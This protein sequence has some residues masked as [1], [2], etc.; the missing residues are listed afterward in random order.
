MPISPLSPPGGG[1][2]LNG[3]DPKLVLLGGVALK[4]LVRR[5]Q[6]VARQYPDGG[7]EYSSSWGSAEPPP[8]AD[9]P[10][11]RLKA[12]LRLVLPSPKPETDLY[13]PVPPPPI[14]VLELDGEVDNIG[15]LAAV[16]ATLRALRPFKVTTLSLRNCACFGVSSNGKSDS[17]AD[18]AKVNG[19]S[20]SSADVAIGLLAAFLEER[21]FND[22]PKA[23]M[24]KRPV[25]ACLEV[26]YVSGSVS[27]KPEPPCDSRRGVEKIWPPPQPHSCPA[28][29]PYLSTK[30]HVLSPFKAGAPGLHAFVGRAK[31]GREA[32]GKRQGE[33]REKEKVEGAAAEEQGNRNSGSTLDSALLAW[34]LDCIYRMVVGARGLMIVL[35]RGA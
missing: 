5:A 14:Q 8:W 15:A 19:K 26:L 22:P 27:R 12:K 28:P 35:R 17:S 2:R 30:A 21:R 9:L 24:D 7:G 32:E 11:C 3:I 16:L 29:T 23:S 33:K 20:D 10:D 6:V 4:E 25:E 18:V 1:V 13:I 34:Y 31:R